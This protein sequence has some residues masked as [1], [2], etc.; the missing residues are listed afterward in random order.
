[1]GIKWV[2]LNPCFDPIS[3]SK[4]YVS[5]TLLRVLTCPLP[6]SLATM[7]I[8]LLQSK[9]VWLLLYIVLVTE[10]WWLNPESMHACVQYAAMIK[11]SRMYMQLQIVVACT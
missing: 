6:T 2:H 8:K 7:A 1:M 3:P 10:D 5:N 11:Y 4:V 9:H